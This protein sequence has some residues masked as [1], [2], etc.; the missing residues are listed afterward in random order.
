MD[1]NEDLNNKDNIEIVVGDTSDLSFSEVGDFMND[2]KPRDVKGSKKNI[3]IPT[4][5]KNVNKNEEDDDE[6][7]TDSQ[8]SN[9]EE[10]NEEKKNNENN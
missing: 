3:I 2:L 10:N 7:D 8:N 5:K 1:E 9:I 6:N 4:N